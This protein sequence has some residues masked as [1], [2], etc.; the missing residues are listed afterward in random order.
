MGV[1]RAVGLLG[2]GAVL[3]CLSSA[4]Q[5]PEETDNPERVRCRRECRDSYT[6]CTK[7]CGGDGPEVCEGRCDGQ[8]RRCYEKCD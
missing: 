1:I 5:K 8:N 7:K 2:W 4:C 6:A 3:F